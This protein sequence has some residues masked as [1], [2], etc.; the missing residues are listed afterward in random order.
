MGLD[1]D[2]YDITTWGRHRGTNAFS[3]A[4]AVLLFG[5]LHLDPGLLNS[6]ARA[7]TR[8]PLN[9]ALQQEAY[10]L[11]E[12]CD[13]QTAA[14]IQQA[15]SRGRCR[16]VMLVNGK[17][18]CRPMLA[19]TALHKQEYEGVLKHLQT[20]F[21]GFTHVPLDDAA[22]QARKTSGEL[23]L[24][25]CEVILKQLDKADTPSIKTSDLRDRVNRGLEDAGRDPIGDKNWS[26]TTK[27]FKPAGWELRG[28]K[29]GQAWVNTGLEERQAL[30]RLFSSEALKDGRG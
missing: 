25:L 21:P 12:L 2:R 17:T 5:T 15:L 6:M 28:Q 14:D 26:R 20:A 29:R 4:S 23:A 9:N 3:Q 8:D 16:E 13:S 30:A 1:L 22:R 27:G 7:A 11:Q 24:E 10:T 18:V 19:F